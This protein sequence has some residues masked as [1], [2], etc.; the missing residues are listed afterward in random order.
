MWL[1]LFILIIAYLTVGLIKN[2]ILIVKFLL[3]KSSKEAD[4]KKLWE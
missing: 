2:L 1:F 3:S 4:R